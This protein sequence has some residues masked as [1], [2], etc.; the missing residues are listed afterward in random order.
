MH[1]H[2]FLIMTVMMALF[3][4]GCNTNGVG[5]IAMLAGGHQ[6]FAA[7]ATN[8]PTAVSRV[9]DTSS[10]H[11]A[12]QVAGRAITADTPRDGW[13]ADQVIRTGSESE[14]S[15]DI[16]SDSAGN[17]Y[18]AFEIWNPTLSTYVIEVRKSTDG[19]RTW[20]WLFAFG[21]D[22]YNWINPSIA[23]DVGWYNTVF[24]VCE[25]QISASQHHI[26]GYAWNATGGQ[27]VY[28]DMNAGDHRYPSL[29][30]EFSYG[31]SNY[32]YVAY[33]TI[34]NNDD[35]DM[36]VQRSTNHGDTWSNCDFRGGWPDANVY[37]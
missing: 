6:S 10:N 3:L 21:S 4:I 15:P 20:N 14:M 26:V 2:R 13:I 22:T 17:L 24:V 19:G 12:S 7:P 30:S 11:H 27:F 25:E 37:C 36:V 18:T 23:V 9:T 16:A 5:P 28:I 33:E 34:T 29:A 35:R 1:I 32:L 8:S 31:S